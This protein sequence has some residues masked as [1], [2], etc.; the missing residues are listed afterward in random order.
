MNTK[1]RQITH[2]EIAAMLTRSASQVEDDVAASLR[3]ARMTALQKQRTHAPVFSL[4]VI[5]DFL[6]HMLAPNT[7]GQ[8]LATAVLLFSIVVGGTNFWEYQH[9]QSVS[10]L[11]I[12]ILTDDLPMEVFID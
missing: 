8:W 3:N 4:E 5:G 2:G 1:N 11:D 6:Q 9:A 10:H 7:A 12:A